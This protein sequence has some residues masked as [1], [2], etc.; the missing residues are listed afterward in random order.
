M[1]VPLFVSWPGTIRPGE[2]DHV[3]ALYDFAATAAELAGLKAPPTDGISFAPTVLGEPEQQR[4]HSYLY[5]EGEG[6]SPHAQS[7]RF[8]TWWAFR[9]HPSQ[10]VQLYDIEKDVSCVNDL[11]GDRPELAKRARAIFAEA[12]TP[13]KWYVN[14]GEDE[15]QVAAKRKLGQA[16]KELT[17]STFPN[18]RTEPR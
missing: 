3:C 9:P 2:S 6:K 18:K 15:N 16:S 7:S 12:H 4:S 8:D 13:G 11:A 10:S 1:R 14:P 17:Q 5:W